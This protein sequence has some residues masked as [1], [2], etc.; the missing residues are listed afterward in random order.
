MTQRN[1]PSDCKNTTQS[2]NTDNRAGLETSVPTVMP[3]KINLE[4][5][6]SA[7]LGLAGLARPIDGCS[8]KATGCCAGE[9]TSE[10]REVVAALEV[11]DNSF[12]MEAAG[13]EVERFI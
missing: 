7:R 5:H 3:G 9:E 11:R 10:E 12:Q 2:P 4:G 1:S 6:S 13:K 8:R